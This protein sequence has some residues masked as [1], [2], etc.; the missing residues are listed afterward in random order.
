MSKRAVITGAFSYMGAAIAAELQARGWQVHTLT[1]RIGPP[2]ASIGASPLRFVQDELRRELMGADVFINTYWIRLPYAGQTFATAVEHS[3]MLLDAAVAAGVRRLVQ[4]SVSNAHRG[5]NLGYYHGKAEVEERVRGLPISHAIVRP[6]LVVG[7]SDVLS[8]NIAWLLRRFP[9]FPVPAARA[10]L[11]PITL[12]ETARIVVDAAEDDG[13]TEVDAA[14]PDVMTF[15]EYVRLVARACRVRRIIFSAPAW[16][17][18]A[19]IRLVEPILGDIILTREELLGLEQELLL[20]HE[21]PLGKQSVAAWLHRH[22]AELGRRYVN[23]CHRHFGA[24]KTKMILD[25]S[26]PTCWMG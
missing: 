20:S 22:G 19:G 23:D 4:V 10:R 7:P 16:L 3:T 8:A 17:A 9:C 6:T 13:D 12:A 25:P 15:M 14:G 2:D 26:Q 24:G 21:P 11:Q 1:N 5:R 18:L